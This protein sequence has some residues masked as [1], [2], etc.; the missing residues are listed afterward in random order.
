MIWSWSLKV[1]KVE[2]ACPFSKYLPT[3]II[4]DVLCFVWVTGGVSCNGFRIFTRDGKFNSSPSLIIKISLFWPE[5]KSCL[6]LKSWLIMHDNLCQSV[7]SKSTVPADWFVCSRQVQTMPTS[8]RVKSNIP[9]FADIDVWLEPAGHG[10][11]VMVN[12]DWGE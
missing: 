10:D 5:T 7:S 12:W 4:I 9:T 3:Y 11:N 8:W 1:Y 2:N 6:F